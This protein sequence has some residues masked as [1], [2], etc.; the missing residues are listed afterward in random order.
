MSL[1]TEMPGSG[2][3][4]FQAQNSFL[5][6][7]Q[8]FYQVSKKILKKCLNVIGEITDFLILIIVRS[9]RF[10]WNLMNKLGCF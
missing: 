7:G 2:T 9:F 3:R 8:P 4:G 6:F 10:W 5:D 1:T